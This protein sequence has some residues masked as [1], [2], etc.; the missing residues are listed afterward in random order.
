MSESKHYWRGQ[1]LS[2]SELYAKGMEDERTRSTNSN[3]AS[4][5]GVADQIKSMI[6][7]ANTNGGD[8]PAPTWWPHFARAAEHIVYDPTGAPA[9]SGQWAIAPEQAFPAT[10]VDTWISDAMPVLRYSRMIETAPGQPIPALPYLETPPTA[11]ARA[12]EKQPMHSVAFDIVP[13]TAIE[14]DAGLYLNVSELLIDAGFGPLTN[15]IMK[16]VVGAEASK[17]IAQAIEAA[18]GT[19]GM[20]NF[21]GSRYVPSVVVV[22]PANLETLNASNYVAAGMTVVIDTAVTKTL[23]VD[24]NAVIGWFRQGR[25]E[26][27]E[28]SVYGTGVAFS[29]YG[30]VAIDP[31]GLAALTPAP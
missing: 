24:P 14:I 18:A 26:Q 12:G 31:A 4:I 13:A 6:L 23:I 10:L 1:L 27:A 7:G 22:P 21:T 25:I 30:K 3:R 9:N 5:Q 11:G 16:S 15:L 20:A 29:A 28:P 17:Q 19:G 2:G 8:D